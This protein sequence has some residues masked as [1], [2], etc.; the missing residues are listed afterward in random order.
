MSGAKVGI[1]SFLVSATPLFSI[2]AAIVWFF[3]SLGGQLGAAGFVVQLLVLAAAALIIVPRTTVRIICTGL[4]FI[5]S[6]LGA[7][8]IGRFYMPAVCAAAGLTIY[9]CRV[10]R[11]RQA[12]FE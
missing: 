5:A 11:R 7:M 12:Q 6:V 1:V 8:T 9:Q 2:A 3:G 4:L 10:D